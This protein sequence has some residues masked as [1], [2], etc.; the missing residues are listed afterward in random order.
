[1]PPPL[2]LVLDSKLR[3][4]FVDE[5]TTVHTYIEPD[6]FRRR[7]N[8]EDYWKREQRL[9]QGG[10]GQVHL[11]KCVAGRSKGELRAVKVLHKQHG[12]APLTDFTRELEAIAKFSHEKVFS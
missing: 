1:M 10:F 9:G 6:G 2:D 4:R 11:E 8:R 5:T 12:P 3:T 7:T